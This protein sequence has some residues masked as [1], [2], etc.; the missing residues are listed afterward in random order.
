WT[1]I[2][3]IVNAGHQKNMLDLINKIEEN[4]V[5]VMMEIN[6]QI[7]QQM[8]L[9]SYCKLGKDAKLINWGYFS[10]GFLSEYIENLPRLIY[11]HWYAASFMGNFPESTAL[12]GH[13]ADSHKGVC[14]IFSTEKSEDTG[15]LCIDIERSSGCALKEHSFNK[16]SYENERV[17]VDFFKRLWR[18]PYYIVENEWYTGDAG[19]KSPLISETNPSQDVRL[20]YWNRFLKIQTTKT[21][22]WEKECEYRLLL[23][24]SFHD[25]SELQSRLFNYKFK[26]LEGIIFGIKTPIDEKAKIIEIIYK[27]CKESGRKDFSFYQARYD[28]QQYKIVYDELDF[29]EFANN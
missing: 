8:N 25:F 12:W 21:E 16:V 6:S 5:D 1:E 18:Q 28:R 14:L 17:R 11:P 26:S 13:Y 4:D 15:R 7:A 27:K 22:D 24:D 3:D 19:Q 10:S 23:D 2:Q 9:R 20:E 29:L